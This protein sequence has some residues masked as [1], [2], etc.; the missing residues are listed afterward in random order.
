[1][2]D[3]AAQSVESARA[4]SSGIGWTLGGVFVALLIF[5]GC[6]AMMSSDGGSST[7]SEAFCNDLR[8]GASPFQI[9][10][11]KVKDG[12]YTPQEAADRAYGMAPIGCPEQ[13]T[14]NEALRGYLE[15][16]GINPDA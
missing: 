5:W 2:G 16:F 6:S 15:G 9:L 8:A 14:S 3:K 4:G 12:T 10:S 1:M 13:L 7:L 11:P